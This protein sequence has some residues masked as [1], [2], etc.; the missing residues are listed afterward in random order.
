MRQRTSLGFGVIG[1][2]PTV[3]IGAP[4]PLHVVAALSDTLWLTTTRLKSMAA[5]NGVEPGVMLN[6]LHAHKKPGTRIGLTDG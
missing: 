3:Y 2:V 6:L 4:A 1:I 5:A